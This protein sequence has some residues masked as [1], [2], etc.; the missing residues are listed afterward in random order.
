VDFVI[1]ALVAAATAPNLNGLVV[2]VG[3]GVETSLRSLTKLM[4]NVTGSS[5]NVV[6]NSQTSAGLSRLSADLTL[7]GQKL[8]YKPAIRLEEGLR[9]TLQRDLRYKNTK[10]LTPPKTN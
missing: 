10:T 9:L 2:N 1:S 6:F 7:A 5:A 8:N 4:L 3:S